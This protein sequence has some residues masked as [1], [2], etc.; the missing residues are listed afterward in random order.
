MSCPNEDTRACVNT[1]VGCRIDALSGIWRQSGS[2]SCSQERELT[3]APE[4]PQIDTSTRLLYQASGV[5]VTGASLPLPM[6]RKQVEGQ[7]GALV[8]PTHASP[9]PSCVLLPASCPTLEGLLPADP[10]MA[11][12]VP[13]LFRNV[14]AVHDQVLG[15]VSSTTSGSMIFRN[16]RSTAQPTEY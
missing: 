7:E 13:V 6:T 14:H 10:Q 8:S 12:C 15:S 16:L 4:E 5:G 11:Q 9:A 1:S 3:F 2:N